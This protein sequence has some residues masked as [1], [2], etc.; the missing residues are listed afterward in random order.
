[1]NYSVHQLY[2]ELSIVLNEAFG[3]C[4]I[5]RQ[6]QNGTNNNDNSNNKLPQIYLQMIVYSSMENAT[7]SM[8]EWA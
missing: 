6:L 4:E 3:E 2:S 8:W 1:M 5:K 7:Y